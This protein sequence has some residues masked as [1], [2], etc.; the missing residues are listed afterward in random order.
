MRHA[1][2]VA[3]AVSN[4]TIGGNPKYAERQVLPRQ[5]GRVGLTV[6]SFVQ[7]ALQP[8]AANAMVQPAAQQPMQQMQPMQQQWGQKGVPQ[9]MIPQQQMQ[10]MAQQPQIQQRIQPMM[11]PIQ[12]ANMM[13]LQQ[14]YGVP[15]QFGRIF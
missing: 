1:N 2:H 7:R 14:Q 12:Q 6:T 10:M 8:W 13:A 11:V 15:G 4:N 3:T 9:Q 5:V